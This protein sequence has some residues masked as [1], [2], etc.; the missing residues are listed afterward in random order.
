MPILTVRFRIGMVNPDAAIEDLL[1]Q[2][3]QRTLHSNC[4]IQVQQNSGTTGNKMKPK[5]MGVKQKNKK[6]EL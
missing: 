3:S 5:K 2:P 1:R 6:S 4:K